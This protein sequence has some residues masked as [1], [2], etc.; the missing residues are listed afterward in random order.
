DQN[1]FQ[2]DSLQL[3][4]TFHAEQTKGVEK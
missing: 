4:W 1:K 2:G 3:N